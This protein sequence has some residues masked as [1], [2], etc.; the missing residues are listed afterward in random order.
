[1]GYIDDIKERKASANTRDAE[2]A[3]KKLAEVMKTT[4]SPRIKY[5]LGENDH[6]N[7]YRIAVTPPPGFAGDITE[8]RNQ[9][10]E[11]LR[12]ESVIPNDMNGNE[13]KVGEHEESPA[14]ILTLNGFQEAANSGETR[15]V[16]PVA[17]YTRLQ[18]LAERCRDAGGL[19]LT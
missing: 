6:P 14:V 8:L 2:Q 9:L 5:N 17:Q 13:I 16:S 7:S 1:M 3:L 19:G 11:L 12:R 15:E 4:S 18:H 10:T